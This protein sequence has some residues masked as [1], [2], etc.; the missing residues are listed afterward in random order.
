MI[1]CLEADEK[2]GA[3]VRESGERKHQGAENSAL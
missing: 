2:Y 1:T 3:T